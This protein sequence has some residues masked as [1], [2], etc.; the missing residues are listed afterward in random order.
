M[1]RTGPRRRNVV[2]DDSR[3]WREKI[4]RLLEPAD[5]RVVAV[6]NGDDA[7]RLCLDPTRPVDL[8]ILDLV[9]PGTDG[10][11]V[12]RT[13]RG[14]KLTA[15]LP[16]VAI[17]SL[18]KKEDFPNGP[19]AQGFDAVLEKAASPDQFMFLFNKYLNP[20]IP[21]RRPAQRLATFLHAT[22]FGPDGRET[23]GAITNLSRSGAFL[24]TAMLLEAGS[25]ISLS[26]ALPE[27]PNLKVKA[28]VVRVNDW[29]AS[30]KNSYSRGMGVLFED[31][32]ESNAR[33]IE[34]FVQRELEGEDP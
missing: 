19:K 20:D 3:F 29:G 25:A 15:D 21:A 14:R 31:L 9:M 22:S 32:A 13:L 30:A 2:A 12:A 11:E 16:I 6:D 4:C 23:R 7:I 1:S 8:L 33:A 26:F 18:F 28:L 24:S 5:H 17:T 10:F 27:G 34:D